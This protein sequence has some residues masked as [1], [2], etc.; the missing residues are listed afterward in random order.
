MPHYDQKVLC[1]QLRI[2]LLRNVLFVELTSHYHN[3]DNMLKCV[4]SWFLHIAVITKEWLIS[5]F[6]QT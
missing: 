6:F 1:L 5:F 2:V 3:C 4:Q